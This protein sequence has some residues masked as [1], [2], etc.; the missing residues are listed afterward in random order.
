M[1]LS[2]VKWSGMGVYCPDV[3]HLFIYLYGHYYIFHDNC[4]D[5]YAQRTFI[6]A[7]SLFK[8]FI[9]SNDRLMKFRVLTLKRSRA[10][11]IY[12]A[13]RT[14]QFSIIK[15]KKK[16]KKKETIKNANNIESNTRSETRVVLKRSLKTP[17]YRRVVF[18]NILHNS[19]SVE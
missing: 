8:K 11:A 15:K 5:K 13:R 18:E 9:A 4:V 6:S 16:K 17:E 12:V 1:A 10:N 7:F 14:Y 3:N 19:I 2:N